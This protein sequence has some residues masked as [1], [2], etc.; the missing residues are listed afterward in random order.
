[1]DEE[2]LALIFPEYYEEPQNAHMSIIDPNH[3]GGNREVLEE[4]LT[5]KYYEQ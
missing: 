5:E 3:P 1:M 2:M 4:E